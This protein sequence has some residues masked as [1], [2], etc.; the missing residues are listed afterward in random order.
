MGEEF[1]FADAATAKFH[2]VAR[3]GNPMT[4]AMGFDLPFDGMDVLNG[5]EIERFSPQEG[6]QGAEKG[7]PRFDVAGHRSGLDH[8]GALPI[9]TGAFVIGFGGHDGKCH[10]GCARIRT[11]TQVRPKRI[12]VRGSILENRNQRA[13]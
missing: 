4:A 11:K 10:R 8:G 12:A 2:V 6:A 13:R 9:L 3:D 5:S 7:V 1:D